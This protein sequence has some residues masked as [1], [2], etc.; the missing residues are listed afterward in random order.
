MTNLLGGRY[1][2]LRELG[3][4][5]CGQTFLAEDV[6]MPSRRRCVVKQLRPTACDVVTQRIIH[7][8][9]EREASVLEELGLLSRQIPTLY[10]YFAENGE[11]Y[12]V[13]EW[14]EGVTLQEKVK[15]DGPLSEAATRKLLVSLLYVLHQVHANGIIHRDI[16]PTNIVLRQRDNQPVLIDFGAVKDLYANGLSAD[17]MP[18]GSIVIGSPGFMSLEQS[19]GRPVFSS[20]VYSLGLTAIY[21][22]TGRTPKELTDKTTGAIRWRDYAPRLSAD[23][24]AVLERA[25]RDAL[26]ERY[27][28]AHEMLEDLENDER[29]HVTVRQVQPL[30]QIRMP[31]PQVA[32]SAAPRRRVWPVWLLALLLAGGNGA[33][34]YYYWRKDEENAQMQRAL[35]AATSDLY[36]ARN[37][38]EASDARARIAEDKAR[39]TEQSAKQIWRVA[40]LNNQTAGAINYEILSPDGAWEPFTLDP[41]AARTHWRLNVEI[42]IKFNSNTGFLRHEKMQA[43]TNV[44]TVLGHEP[45]E[46]EQ[47]K[48]NSFAFKK[49]ESMSEIVLQ[50]D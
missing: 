19:A 11:L 42:M 3:S 8:R 12:L 29:T 4:G 5:G 2:V 37:A 21:L 10:D 18:T 13:Q 7:E 6:N 17:G 28:N 31:L 27:Q 30:P 35:T 44:T 25:T 33:W 16:K 48:A 20:D 47:N 15:R 38:K 1:N 41:G 45:N 43:L 39:K 36:E 49:D 34:A 26:P 46:T 22:L 32:V 24:A 40:T 9:F 50:E 23:F 14:I